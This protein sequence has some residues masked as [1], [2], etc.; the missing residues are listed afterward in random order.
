MK[1]RC[2]L[3]LPQPPMFRFPSV[4]QPPN[5]P[6]RNDIP[7][8]QSTTTSSSSNGSQ[9]KQNPLRFGFPDSQESLS[10][11]S[12]FVPSSIQFGSLEPINRDGI[13]SRSTAGNNLQAS[14]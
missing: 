8:S 13:G 2:L 10:S 9:Q 14:T 12:H 3:N 7:V 6:V 4:S 5:Y 1:V 11:N